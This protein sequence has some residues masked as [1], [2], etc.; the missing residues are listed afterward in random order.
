MSIF[1]VLFYILLIIPLKEY[2][3]LQ[4]VVHIHIVGLHNIIYQHIN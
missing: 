2:K 3:I 4:Y 1:A